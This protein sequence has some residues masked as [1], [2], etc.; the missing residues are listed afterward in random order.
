[1]TGALPRFPAEWPHPG[2]RTSSKPCSLET[3][4][5]C[6]D[7][8]RRHSRPQRRGRRAALEIAEHDERSVDGGE[9]QTGD[10]PS[11]PQPSNRTC[12]CS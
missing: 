3:L 8:L 4:K 12:S 1:M 10:R 9:E 2:M 5:E 11:A 7:L 6:L